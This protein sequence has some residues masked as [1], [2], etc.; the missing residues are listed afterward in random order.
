MTEEKIAKQ[1]V[2]GYPSRMFKLKKP[3]KAT[4]FIGFIFLITTILSI[5]L[6]YQFK[7]NTIDSLSNSLL[8]QINNNI[9]EITTNFLMPAIVLAESSARL[10][11]EGALD[12]NNSLQIEQY[13]KASIKPHPQIQGLYYGDKFGNFYMIKKKEDQVL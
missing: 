11:E 3:I 9:I 4:T 7:N 5:G 2:L 8:E 12:V 13:F 6:T 1:K 10:A